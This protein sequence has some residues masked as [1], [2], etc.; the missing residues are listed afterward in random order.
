MC[1]ISTNAGLENQKQFSKSIY[2]Y[3]IFIAVFC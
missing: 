2:T 1:V 3:N